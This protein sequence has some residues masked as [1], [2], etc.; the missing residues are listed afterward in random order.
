VWLLDVT[1]G[2]L[3]RFTNAPSTEGSAV[4]SPDG[5]RI[6]FSSDRRGGALN[7]YVKDLDGT[8]E[9]LLLEASTDHAA[10]DL[11]RDGRYVLYQE[12][13]THTG[14][15]LWALP[16]FGDRKPFVAVQT[17]G[18]DLMGQ[19]SPD[20]RWLAYQSDESGRPEVYV[21][22]FPSGAGRTQVS[23]DGGTA[24][25]WRSDG[26]ELYYSTN[27]ER[28]MSAT[29]RVTGSSLDVGRPAALFGTPRGAILVHADGQ[30]FLLAVTTQPA[31]PIT[32]LLNWEGA[33][34]PR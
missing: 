1:R 24:P 27:G 26:G 22:A 23:T 3:R 29:I 32:L 21:Q 5:R 14:Q 16:Q 33:R 19:F 6:V 8:E 28:V 30:R 2:A 4:W 10:T 9:A 20:G 34:A 7:L 12:L 13:S 11:S 18:T 31:S 25:R 17:G 15:D